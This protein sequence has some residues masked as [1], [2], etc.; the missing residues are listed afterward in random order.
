MLPKDGKALFL[1]LRRIQ[2]LEIRL[3]RLPRLILTYTIQNLL[4]KKKL[5]II[6]TVFGKQMFGHTIL[7]LRKQQIL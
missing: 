5:V 6:L 3:E 2:K 1:K 7:E 4:Q